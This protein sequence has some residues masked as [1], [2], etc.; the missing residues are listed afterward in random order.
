[1]YTC[2]SLHG[3]FDGFE[4]RRYLFAAAPGECI[5]FP[6]I[7]CPH[8]TTHN[9]AAT[10]TLRVLVGTTRIYV[11]VPTKT[12]DVLVVRIPERLSFAPSQASTSPYSPLTRRRE[13]INSSS[14]PNDALSTL[15]TYETEAP[16]IVHFRLINGKPRAAATKG[17][18]QQ[19]TSP[20]AST[21]PISK[22]NNVGRLRLVVHQ[23]ESLFDDSVS[24]HE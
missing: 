15:A 22:G 5:R 10:L 18:T 8:P 13:G 2:A 12:T 16:P 24:V 19:T 3:I 1:M 17:S 4:T 23:G 20:I 9:I 21:P 14:L 7:D 11:L 6:I